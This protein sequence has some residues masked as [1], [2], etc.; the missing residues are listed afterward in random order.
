M[1]DEGGVE[2]DDGGEDEM[3]A[4]EIVVDVEDEKDEIK[5]ELEF[6]ER[7][8][9][10]D[11]EVMKEF[12][13]VGVSTVDDDCDADGGV[14][15]MKM[16]AS[17]FWSTVLG[18]GEAENDD[19]CESAIDSASF[20]CI[21]ASGDIASGGVD[22]TKSVDG[23]ATVNKDDGRLDDAWLPK[24]ESFSAL[25]SDGEFGRL[26]IEEF[27]RS[28]FTVLF[29]TRC[30]MR[31]TLSSSLVK[32]KTIHQKP[33]LMARIKSSSQTC[34]SGHLAA[35]VTISPSVWVPSLPCLHED[36]LTLKLKLI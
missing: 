1:A 11:D 21:A 26:K 4:D 7:R 25:Q 35:V 30:F 22:G 28:T 12:T 27:I 31:S 29:R 5:V 6:N 33:H 19:K 34:Q 23:L 15:G 10:A 9:R 3:D 17:I 13:E 2:E 36:Y 18:T 14:A 8:R 24:A 16:F 20:S 32:Q